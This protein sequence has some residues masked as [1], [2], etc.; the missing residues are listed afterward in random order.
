MATGAGLDLCAID[1]DGAQLGQAHLA[2][3]ANDLHKQF[4]ELR[5][6]Q[7]AK[8]A[9][10]AVGGEVTCRQH[11]KGDVLVELSGDFAEAGTDKFRRQSG[12][13]RV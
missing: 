3:Q 2:C 13:P 8:L 11:P 10:G 9:D 12:T 1:C 4:G 6:M 5:Q 7:G